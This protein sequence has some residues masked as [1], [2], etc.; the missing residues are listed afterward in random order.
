[1]TDA[2]KH[3]LALMKIST[4]HKSRGDGVFLGNPQDECDLSY[5]S[6]LFSYKYPADVVG[7]TAVDPSIR[8]N[9]AFD[10]KP[11]YSLFN[12]DYSVGFT[13]EYC[14]NKCEFCVVPKQSNPKVHHSIWEFHD[15][16]FKQ[17]CL[18]NNNTFS[19]PKWRNTF[20]EILEA[21]LTIIDENGYDLRLLDDEKV[22]YLNKTKF[23]TTVHFAW[24]KVED[25]QKIRNGLKVLKQLTHTKQIYVMVGFPNLRPI[26]E[27][28]LHR[29]QVIVDAG[30]DPFVMVYNR[31]HKS[32]SPIMRQLNQFQR[33]VNRTYIWRKLGFKIAWQ[34]YKS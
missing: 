17:I 28:D 19:D 15:P 11:D 34:N 27:T 12:L 32:R 5:A 30:F 25:E 7:G 6:W 16:Q 24:D 9:G 3:N 22:E 18:L 29:C 33:M 14:P 10:C 1:M 21:G 8:L 13:W 23:S 31:I 2:T 26:D 4:Y 20:D